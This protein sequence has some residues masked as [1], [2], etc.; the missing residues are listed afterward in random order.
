MT[1][2]FPRHASRPP[3]MA[4]YGVL[5]PPAAAA[6]SSGIPHRTGALRHSGHG[7][8]S[9]PSHTYGVQ[10]GPGRTSRSGGSPAVHAPHRTVPPSASGIRGR[11]TVSSVSLAS[12]SPPLGIK[13]APAGFRCSREGPLDI[14]SRY[15]HTTPNKENHPRYY[16]HRPRHAFPYSSVTSLPRVRFFLLYAEE[17]SMPKR[18]QMSYTALVWL[19]ESE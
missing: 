14:F 13:K 16:S 9:T 8:I 4:A 3:L 18:S 7:F 11:N 19:S 1:Q 17:R 5:P 2:G 15:Q 6:P 12:A 10:P